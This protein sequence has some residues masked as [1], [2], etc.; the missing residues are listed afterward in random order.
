MQIIML[1]LDVLKCRLWG[2]TPESGCLTSPSANA[3]IYNNVAI[4]HKRTLLFTAQ[5]AYFPSVPFTMLTLFPSVLWQVAVETRVQAE[6][7]S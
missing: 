1:H 6:N 5:D 3:R 7:L 4:P 2:W